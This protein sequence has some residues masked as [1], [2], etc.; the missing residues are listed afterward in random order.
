MEDKD[1]KPKQTEV[2][3]LESTPKKAKKPVKDSIPIVDEKLVEKSKKVQE[4]LK[5][6][7][8]HR[9]KYI[10]AE[11]RARQAREEAGK[12]VALAGA[13]VL[14]AVDVAQVASKRLNAKY[15][16]GD[17]A[18]IDAVRAATNIEVA[19]TSFDRTERDYQEQQVRV[20]K[21]TLRSDII[22]LKAEIKTLE[23]ENIN[24]DIAKSQLHGIG[25]EYKRRTA[26]EDPTE[27]DQKDI[28][29][30][31]A[32]FAEVKG[33]I[34]RLETRMAFRVQDIQEKENRLTGEAL[35]ELE[36]D[37][38]SEEDEYLQYAVAARK[39]NKD[40]GKAIIEARK[41]EAELLKELESEQ[42][43]DESK[44]QGFL[45]KHDDSKLIRTLNKATKVKK[46]VLKTGL[47][48]FDRRI[49]EAEENIEE[50]L[51]KGHDTLIYE[52][53]LEE[54]KEV[55]EKIASTKASAQITET[56][57]QVL[58]AGAELIKVA[59]DIKGGITD[60]ET[61]IKGGLVDV[62]ADI[63]RLLPYV[64]E[65]LHIGLHIAAGVVRAAGHTA[66]GLERV[67]GETRR[68][69][70]LI[71]AEGEAA[72]T[73]MVADAT[74]LGLSD[75]EGL[76]LAAGMRHGEVERTIAFDRVGEIMT[77]TGERV[78]ED[79]LDA[80]KKADI[81]IGQQVELFG[82]EGFGQV[83]L[84]G[85]D[86]QGVFS[87]YGEQGQNLGS[88]FG[89]FM[90]SGNMND[91]TSGDALEA[92]GLGT[93]YRA[94][95]EGFIG[96][97]LNKASEAG[98]LPK[99]ALE[100]QLKALEGSK[101]AVKVQSDYSVVS[102]EEKLKNDFTERSEVSK[103]FGYAH[104]FDQTGDREAAQR[105]ASQKSPAIR[106]LLKGKEDTT[107]SPDEIAHTSEDVEAENSEAT[108]YS[109]TSMRYSGSSLE[110]RDDWIRTPYGSLI[111]KESSTTKNV[112][113]D[114]VF[115]GI[116][117]RSKGGKAA[118]K[119]KSVKKRKRRTRLI[120]VLI[121]VVL[122]FVFFF[123]ISIS[124][125]TIGTIGHTVVNQHHSSGGGQVCNCG[126]LEQF[127]SGG[128]IAGDG[129][130]YIGEDIIGGSLENGGVVV[131]NVPAEVVQTRNGLH[132][133]IYPQRNWGVFEYN[134]TRLDTR[135]P[136]DSDG[137]PF[138]IVAE[139]LLDPTTPDTSRVEAIT[140][141]GNNPVYAR[142]LVEE[143]S[144]ELS[145]VLVRVNTADRKA[146]TFNKYPAESTRFGSLKPYQN[147]TTSAGVDLRP[148][149][150]D[151]VS[152]NLPSGLIQT[153]IAYPNSANAG[154]IIPSDGPWMPGNADA[155]TI[156]FNQ[157]S[158]LMDFRAAHPNAKLLQVSVSTDRALLES[159]P[160]VAPVYTH[161]FDAPPSEVPEATDDV[162][163]ATDV[164]TVVD[165]AD[166]TTDTENA[167][168]VDI[169]TTEIKNEY[170][171][172]C[173][174]ALD[175]LCFEIHGT[176]NIYRSDGTPVGGVPYKEI[177]FVDG[178]PPVTC[179][180]LSGILQQLTNDGV[181]TERLQ[182]LQV[183]MSLTDNIPRENARDDLVDCPGGGVGHEAHSALAY[184]WGGKSPKGWNTSWGQLKEI[185]IAGSNVQS[186]GSMWKFGLD[187]SGYTMWVYETALDM[188]LPSS[189]A[190][191]ASNLSS[192]KVISESELQ[193]GDIALWEGH[194]A[195]YCTTQPD[196]TKLYL[197]A[198][199]TD[200]GVVLA[201]HGGTATFINLLD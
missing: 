189:T 72:E 61:A 131:F 95:A 23:A 154:G 100:G 25:M 103:Q 158:A 192:Y 24:L 41:D 73:R 34:E 201:P 178:L 150:D 35:V 5:A 197:Q 82:E 193:P 152:Y 86:S 104:W 108:T 185:T 195:I 57:T 125:L 94:A 129:A 160:V 196:G 132:K 147:I 89:S 26:I 14:E 182:V 64:G 66:S 164:D 115:E 139:K 68:G 130:A 187:C 2:V 71:N 101:K 155:S 162:A 149:V 58:S 135:P 10:D 177:P 124:F 198:L 186:V 161:Q 37:I 128:G 43:E 170:R 59:S 88:I 110:V 53:T 75:A 126:C 122:I 190:E 188:V 96:G 62:S 85:M 47:E 151:E 44:L 30:L 194:V 15:S 22:D 102:H 27:E 118:K 52:Q 134:G 179:P 173:D 159:L 76:G 31:E 33:K 48:I 165:T 81:E 6:L 38:L 74:Q 167:D 112:T 54:L 200:K 21:L 166:E 105:L 99:G 168:T 113:E 29:T 184:F 138:V 49:A 156:E 20:S 136:Y 140:V 116:Q 133:T 4:E 98:L 121:A 93:V 199:S 107:F 174:C 137:L 40:L 157:K 119:I 84:E 145:A 163:D 90:A 16:R 142:L 32:L 56:K 127:Y 79:I 175:C 51:E 83:F 65:G 143:K 12:K 18:R 36:K 8:E 171:I 77:K 183:G 60:I 28:E 109:A 144:G 19:E 120:I 92:L 55:R 141:Y 63:S 87:S 3:P 70:I 91:F 50:G 114:G 42:A 148:Y 176:D 7:N 39:S 191:W 172:I 1:K 123:N 17:G 11:M 46:E 80:L 111:R 117:K 13:K 106:D 9:D 97:V 181:S 45:S 69:E 146:H 78:V 169:P 180:Y 153:G 67:L